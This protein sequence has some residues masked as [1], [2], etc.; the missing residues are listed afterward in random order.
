MCT[1][2]PSLGALF[3]VSDIKAAVEIMSTFN[4]HYQLRLAKRFINAT[5]DETLFFN[6]RMRS[7]KAR[8]LS[9]VIAR[10]VGYSGIEGT[11]Q[12]RIPHFVD[13]LHDGFWCGILNRQFCWWRPLKPFDSRTCQKFGARISPTL[14]TITRQP[15]ELESCGKPENPVRLA[16]SIKWKFGGC[17]GGDIISGGIGLGLFG[18]GYLTQGSHTLGVIICLFFIMKLGCNPHLLSPWL[19][20]QPLWLASYDKKSLIN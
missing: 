19:T 7:L 6:F 14:S 12:R 9:R 5:W 17:L 1:L 3:W 2:A 16:P 10:Y 8:L 4:E 15:I 11:F 18:Q 20:L 13:I